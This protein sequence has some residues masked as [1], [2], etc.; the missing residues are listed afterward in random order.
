MISSI[1]LSDGRPAPDASPDAVSESPR[2]EL[3][4][5][6]PISRITV[7][8]PTRGLFELDLASVWQQRELLYFL[9]WRAVKVRY[10]QAAIGLGWVIL[11]P[12]ITMA[13]FTVVFGRL[14]KIPSDGLPYSVFALSGLLPWMLFSQAVT[15]G[16]G[17]LVSDSGLITKVYFPRLLIPFSAVAVPLV[18]FAVS[19]V[20]LFGLMGWH[21]IEPTWRIVMLPLFVLLA[22]MTS[23]AVSLWLAPL[24][25]RYRDVNHAIPFIVQVWLYASPVVYPTSMV[26]E[27]WRVLYGLNPMTG[28]IDGFRWALL[29][30]PI[31]EPRMLVVGVITTSV[32]LLCGLVYFKRQER[33]FAD[34][35]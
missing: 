13:V 5:V 22:L 7:I 19:S 2:E 3:R 24:N 21:G 23:L 27:K 35:V 6:K 10:K 32:A 4:Q 16:G 14:A 8:Q 26:A 12:L 25:V 30:Q 28:V 29:G 17:S 34:V 20:I 9:V 33:T 18:D 15:R 1:G 11:Q 31:S